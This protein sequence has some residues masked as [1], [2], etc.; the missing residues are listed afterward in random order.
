MRHVIFC[1]FI[2]ISILFTCC[3]FCNLVVCVC[4]LLYMII[5]LI[6]TLITNR[7]IITIN[8][9]ALCVC[10]G[11]SWGRVCLKKQIIITLCGLKC[12][13]SES[14]S[15]LTRVVN[16]IDDVLVYLRDIAIRAILFALRLV[17]LWFDKVYNYT[18]LLFV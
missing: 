9:V 3:I 2:Y 7:C 17:H 8:I 15:Q 12:I 6:I 1:M 11:A 18:L 10:T 4:G 14:C 16:A 5:L 13:T